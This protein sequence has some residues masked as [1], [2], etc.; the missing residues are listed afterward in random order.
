MIQQVQHDGFTTVGDAIQILTNGQYDGPLVEAPKMMR[1]SGGVYVLFFSSACYLDADYDTSYATSSSPTAGF[2]KTTTP[3]LQEGDSG[4]I[5]PG[6]AS[7]ATDGTSMAFHGYASQ[8]D[9]GG[10]RAMY[11]AQ[12]SVSGDTVGY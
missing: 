8:S 11:V 6:G 12:I 9:V 3:L 4:L 2:V 7:V 5:G 1:S 10:R